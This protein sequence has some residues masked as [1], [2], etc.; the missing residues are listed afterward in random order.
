MESK[1]IDDILIFWFGPLNSEGLSK[2]EQQGLWFKS[3]ADTDKRCDALFGAAVQRAIAGKLD[4]WAGSDRGLLALILL[5]DQFPRNIY[6]G[7]PAAFSGDPR[8]LSL[9]LQAIADNRH[10]GIPLIHRVFLYLP[11]EHSEDKA[12]Q[13]QCVALFEEMA[14]ST[15][16]A[17]MA[18][19]KRYAVAHRDVIARFGRFPHRN[20]LLG[21]QSTPAETEHLATHGGF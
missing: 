15:G 18:D 3:S 11:L 4:E 19:F 2:P 14:V 13:Q 9:A 20:A 21:R 16:L 10:L 1:L 7:T 5:T 8:A 6:R 12:V 17:Q